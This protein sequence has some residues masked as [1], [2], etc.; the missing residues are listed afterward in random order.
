VSVVVLDRNGLCV[1]VDISYPRV[2]WPVLKLS[3][4]SLFDAVLLCNA[5]DVDVYETI[6]KQF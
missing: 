5:S 3:R 2:G 4:E 6:P 1:R